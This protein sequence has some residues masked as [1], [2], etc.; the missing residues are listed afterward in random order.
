[1]KW[2]MIS[3]ALLTGMAGQVAA[4]TVNAQI[5]QARAAATAYE[6]LSVARAAGW[7]P[8]G[9]DEP[10]MGQHWHRR[11]GVDYV[12]G[13]AVDP[14]RPSNL[15]YTDIGGRMRLVALAYN[16]RIAPGEPVPEGFVGRS[17]EWHVHDIAAFIAAAGADRPVLRW[18]ATGWLD[19]DIVQRDGKTRV[20]MVHLWLIP[21]PDG[22]F[23]SHNRTLSYL[24][25][26]LPVDW[27]NGASMDAARGLA[28][29]TANGCDEALDSKLW[30]ANVDR[31]TSRRL[32]QGCAQMADFVREGLPGDKRTTNARAASA[33]QS[34]DRFLQD[35]L[36][37]EQKQRIAAI[38]EHGM[39]HGAMGHH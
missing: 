10:L 37:A 24:D 14:L 19:R 25:L 18:L 15:L 22:V 12:S 13:M 33:W 26:G 17:D 21:N 3:L 29:A 9:G 30:V 6:D 36:T 23:A 8:F 38:S 7:R 2:M 1:M 16:V 27:A 31:S 32:A 35:T 4:Q 28:L 39:D 11:D 34:F 20:A 5:S